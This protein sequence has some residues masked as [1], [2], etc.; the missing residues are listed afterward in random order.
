MQDVLDTE[1]IFRLIESVSSF[2]AEPFKLWLAKLGKKVDEAFDP[3]KE[4]D[5]IIDFYFKKG[6][7][8]EWIE[9]GIKA[10]INRKN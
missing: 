8:L 9:T 10:I 4:I 5:Q 3:F 2:K 7:S 6:Y 1:G